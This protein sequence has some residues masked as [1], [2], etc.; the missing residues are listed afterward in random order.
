M[1][2]YAPQALNRSLER[3]GDC[4]DGPFCAEDILDALPQ[5]YHR[6]VKAFY[7]LSF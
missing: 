6:A 2:R 5:D 1:E 3:R 4:W 7:D